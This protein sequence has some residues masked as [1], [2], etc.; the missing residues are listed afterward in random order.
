MAVTMQDIAVKAQVTKNTVSVALRGK[1]GVSPSTRKKIFQVA[2]SL[3]YTPNLAAR[4]LSS[5]KSGLV[6]LVIDG[7]MDYITQKKVS[8]I[9]KKL[10]DKGYQML[11]GMTHSVY[12]EQKYL[13]TFRSRSVEVIIVCGKSKALDHNLYRDCSCPVI[14]LDCK[15]DSPNVNTVRIDRE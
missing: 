7:P 10:Q 4:A 2:K 3:G 8:E 13:E 14:V 9:E 11:L 15:S 6:G 1:N 12:D 5:G